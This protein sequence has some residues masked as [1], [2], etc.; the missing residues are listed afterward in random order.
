MSID[1][2]R[3][4]PRVEVEFPVDVLTN[5]GALIALTALNISHG[6][7]QL[8]CDRLTAESLVLKASVV[9]PDQGAEFELRW[10][11]PGPGNATVAARARLVWS[12]PSE[13]G[14]HLLG[15]A[16]VGIDDDSRAQVERFLVESMTS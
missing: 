9:T 8:G 7:M 10:I 13:G 3:D 11:L 4:L 15:L 16:F 12:R 14:R 6:G 1:N 2:R 5:S